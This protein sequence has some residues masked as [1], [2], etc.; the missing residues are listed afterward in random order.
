[1]TGFLT[2]R[3]LATRTVRL[4]HHVGLRHSV[5]GL[6]LGPVTAR[7]DSSPPG[8]SVRVRGADVVVGVREGAPVP[9]APPLLTVTVADPQLALV[10]A[11]PSVSV[12]LTAPVIELD[13]DPVPMVLAVELRATGGGPGTGRTVS[14]RA[15]RGP[16]PKPTVAL[17]EVAPGA[18]ESAAVVWTAP[19]LPL[20]LLV[21]AAPLRQVALD[22]TRTRT[23]V[24][25]VDT[26]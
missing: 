9:A 24:S 7:L 21:G 8:W 12:P 3:P 2:T 10:L 16:D 18:Y 25:A 26:V 23:R 11:T 1:V 20:D 4:A 6:P 5:T 22:L 17:L 15:T 14:A 19:F 13:V